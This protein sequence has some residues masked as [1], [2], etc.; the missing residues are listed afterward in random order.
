MKVNVKRFGFNNLLQDFKLMKNVVKMFNI[1]RILKSWRR[2]L[3][4]KRLTLTSIINSSNL[5]YFVFSTFGIIST[6]ISI[7][8]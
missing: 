2:L 4:P 7:D 8:R 5:D 6:F 3:K 1:F